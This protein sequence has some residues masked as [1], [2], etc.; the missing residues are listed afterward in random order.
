[1]NGA[2]PK[3]GIGSYIPNDG[4]EIDLVFILFEDE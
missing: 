4:D 2:M 1:M 3:V